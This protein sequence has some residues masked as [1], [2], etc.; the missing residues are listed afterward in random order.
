[1]ADKVI[2]LHEKPEPADESSFRIRYA[3]VL[4]PSQFQAVAHRDGPLL[5]IAGAGSGKTRTLIYR[6]ARLIESGVAPGAILLLTFTRRAAQ[7]MLRRAEQLVG[8]RS[9]SVAGGTFHSF[10][11]LM[12][13]HYGQAAGIKPNFTILD[14]ADMEDVLNLLRARM[15]LASRERRFPKKST[16]AE[17]ISMARN[18]RRALEQE[19]EADFPHLIEHAQELVALDRQYEAYK[20]ERGLLD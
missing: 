18:K 8:D 9:R 7:E 17:V 16:L 15:G 3:E 14:R 1:M 13:R 20:R 6:V 19:I 2:L 10:A 11:N 5:V 12:L 4:N